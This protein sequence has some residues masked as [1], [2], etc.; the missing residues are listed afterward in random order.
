MAL[1]S[2]ALHI[3]THKTGTTSI[4]EYLSRN[5][6]AFT[7]RGVVFPVGS[8]IQSNHVELHIS[9]LR[10]E[11][12]S[13]YKSLLGIRE[14]PPELLKTTR[15][16]VLRSLSAGGSKTIF[17]SEGLS[18]LRFPDEVDRIASIIQA[19]ICEVI[20]FRRE[21]GA[22]LRSYRKQLEKSGITLSSDPTSFAY[23][24]NDS[25]LVDFDS[26]V[27]A[28]ARRF[29]VRVV[30]YEQAMIEF[31]SV[32]PAFLRAIDIDTDTAPDWTGVFENVST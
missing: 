6:V 15:E 8:F 1:P 26:L 18:Y 7:E 12:L 19:E 13:P 11:R 32:I 29:P 24:E 30:S 14:P 3:G 25:W 10:G 16:W 23:V 27:T 2:V 17:S 21:P 22:F 4:Q 20:V 9:A 5:R 31:G 28:F